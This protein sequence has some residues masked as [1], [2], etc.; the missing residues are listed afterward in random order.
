MFTRGYHI[1]HIH[2]IHDPII[3]ASAHQGFELPFLGI[4]QLHLL[5]RV[6][7]AELLD[8]GLQDEA[9]SMGFGQGALRG[10]EQIQLKVG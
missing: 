7:A 4:F 1:H 6:L 9:A 3:P 8:V 5:G 2:H 10:M